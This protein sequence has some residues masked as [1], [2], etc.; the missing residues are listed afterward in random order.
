[1]LKYA[2]DTQHLNMN[3]ED[4]NLNEF[5]TK[6]IADYNLKIEKYFTKACHTLNLTA[7]ATLV[8]GACIFSQINYE[9]LAPEDVI[10]DR[11]KTEEQS[12][13]PIIITKNAIENIKY[14]FTACGTLAVCAMSTWYLGR[15][16]S[17][18]RD[19]YLL[20]IESVDKK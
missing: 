17:K 2:L 3:N 12:V 20:Q 1:M 8:T 16:M 7:L 15:R 4:F 10:G 13:S 19:S 5:Q 9:N 18:E 11:S 6:K 14:G